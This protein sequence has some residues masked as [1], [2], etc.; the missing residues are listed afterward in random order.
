[1]FKS[2]RSSEPKW[3]LKLF[4][5]M[6]DRSVGVEWTVIEN[7]LRK[8]I[9]RRARNFVERSIALD[10]L[11]RLKEVVSVG[12]YSLLNGKGYRLDESGRLE[13]SLYEEVLNEVKRIEEVKKEMQDAF[14]NAQKATKGDLFKMNNGAWFEEY[15]IEVK[16]TSGLEVWDL[17]SSFDCY[18]GKVYKIHRR[19]LSKKKIRRL[20]LRKVDSLEKELLHLIDER[21]KR[22]K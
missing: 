2:K 14:V 4:S 16:D 11:I 21:K 12:R 8:A 5:E 3:V 22:G 19:Q 13:A 10:R 18:N 6:L 9:E 1:M 15:R 20:G 17:P 7:R